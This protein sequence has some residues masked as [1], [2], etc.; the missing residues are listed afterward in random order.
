[1]SAILFFAYDIGADLAEGDESA[2]HIFFEF[3]IFIAVSAV[4]FGEL[5]HVKQLTQEVQDHQ[6]RT[7]RLSGDLLKVMQKP[8][9]TMGPDGL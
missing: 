6:E 9:H 5:R 8:I 1:M 2:L 3:V 4:L 7:A